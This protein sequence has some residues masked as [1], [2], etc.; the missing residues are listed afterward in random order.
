M[1]VLSCSWTRFEKEGRFKK[2]K[3][4]ET[5]LRTP[6]E[7]SNIGPWCCCYGPWSEN[8][9]WKPLQR[10]RHCFTSW[11]RRMIFLGGGGGRVRG[12][13]CSLHV[14]LGFWQL[15][16]LHLLFTTPRL[17]F[18]WIPSQVFFI[19]RSGKKQNI[20]PPQPKQKRNKLQSYTLT[21]QA[22]GEEG[23]AGGAIRVSWRRF[24]QNIV[25]QPWEGDKPESGLKLKDKGWE[26]SRPRGI[27]KVKHE[28]SKWKILDWSTKDET[29]HV[30]GK[31][32]PRCLLLVG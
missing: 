2:K 30:T 3:H 9:V 24:S 31:L 6:T 1:S 5:S 4:P 27:R 25:A 12:V 32:T 18:R 28:Y 13:T 29:G 23:L 19:Q 17:R 14:C 8:H 11:F 16:Q 15:L 22:V 10:R 7:S 26:T 20:P 21:Y